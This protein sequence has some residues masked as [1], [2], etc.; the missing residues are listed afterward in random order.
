[1]I[2]NDIAKE[3]CG[4][5]EKMINKKICKSKDKKNFVIYSSVTN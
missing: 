1:M 5:E 4:R 2:E 3:T